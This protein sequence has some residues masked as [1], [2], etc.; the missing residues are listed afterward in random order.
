MPD[1]H[2]N[3]RSEDHDRLSDELE[4]RRFN[5]EKLIKWGINPWGS[6][7]EVTH[8]A[9]DL[10][11]KFDDTPA[12]EL[13][14][15]ATKVAIAGRLIA[16]RSHGK[17]CFGDLLDGS[18]SI[19]LFFRFNE[20]KEKPAVEGKNAPNQWDL[21]QAVNLGDWI[22]V[23]GTMM[24]TRTGE[25]TVRVADW[26]ILAKAL[27]PMPEKYHGL[28][29][30]EL[31][32]RH[33]YLDLIANP[34]VREVFRARTEVIKV[35]RQVLDG[36]RF[37][38]VETPSLHK[39]AGGAAA[40]PFMTHLNALDMD[41]KLR[42]SLELHLKRLMIGGFERVYEIGR[43]FRNEGMDR[44]HNPEFTMLE[45][46]EAFGDLE[47]MMDLTE[48]I[49]RKACLAVQG[50]T[51]SDFRGHK[52][53]FGPEFTREDFNE[54]MK[55]HARV[56][57]E[58]TRDVASLAMI[59][60]KKGLEVEDDASFGRLVDILFD[61]VVQPN[62]VQP[63][64]VINHPIETSPLARKHPERE[65]FV[66]RF[67]LFVTGHELANAFTELNDPDEQRE[68]FAAQAKLRT[69]GDEEAHPLD[70]DFL[71]ALEH[72]MP[73]AGGMGLGVDRLVMMVT[74]AHSIRDV[75]FFPMMR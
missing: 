39:I 74:G 30:K 58:T 1:E 22:G 14:T 64:F 65:N 27:R 59:C 3:Q 75:I 66:Q 29:D 13:E 6:R 57:L 71:L 10:R 52:L 67:E 44:D 47:T 9:D 26:R 54:L 7:F 63:T 19:Q 5:L 33:R 36:R 61:A 55:R 51:V 50:K 42:I 20:L 16:Y 25:L 23:S 72:G 4:S 15:R 17:A 60:E 31:R 11:T 28:Q 32:Y 21:L 41:L 70:K 37:L 56:D 18:G 40:R 38:E 48:E 69:A 68:R 53:D 45:V 62:L 49:C 12:E 2:E 34:E 24:K 35:T 73:P 43:I 8:C 46:Y